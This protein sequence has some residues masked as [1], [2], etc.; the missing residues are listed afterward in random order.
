MRCKLFTPNY[1]TE[2]GT[3]N[4]FPKYAEARVTRAPGRYNGGYF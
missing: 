4:D 1:K 2:W 3:Y